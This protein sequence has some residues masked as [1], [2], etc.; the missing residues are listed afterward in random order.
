[1]FLSAVTDRGAVPAL[2]KTLVFNQAKLRMI[3]D[4]IANI[5]TPN[6]RAK[7][8][9]GKAFQQALRKALDARGDDPDT[10]FVVKSGREVRTDRDGYLQVTPTEHQVQNVLFHDGTNLSIE[11]EMAELARTGMTHEL[12]STLLRHSLDRLRKVISETRP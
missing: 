8:L 9:D 4:N 1:M 10:P 7:Q 3:A 12:A 5:N 6:Y 2:L 11:R